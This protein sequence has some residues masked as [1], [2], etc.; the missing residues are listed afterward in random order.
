MI[1]NNDA[2][3]LCLPVCNPLDPLGCDVGQGCYPAGDQFLCAPDQSG[4]GGAT[5]D[6]CEFINNCESGN[7][8]VEAGLVPGCVGGLGCCAA[9]CDVTDPA[10]NCG[11][12]TSCTDWYRVGTAPDPCSET[13]GVCVTPA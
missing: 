6:P 4:P 9:T 12:G 10:P 1:V 13:F 11:N 2:L 8:C 7:V 5:G 3:T